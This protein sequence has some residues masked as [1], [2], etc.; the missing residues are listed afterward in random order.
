MTQ[1][2]W[3][4]IKLAAATAIATS[5]AASAGSFKIVY[6]FQG[7][8][9]GNEPNAGLINV[10]GMLYG[11]TT[12]GG[13]GCP[14]GAGCG[15]VFAVNPNT[16]AEKVIYYF[17]GGNDGNF[18]FAS[19]LSLGGTLYGT[20]ELGGGTMCNDLGCGTVFSVNPTTGVERV[21]Y[22]FQAGS[23]GYEP[24]ASLISV[25][26]ILYGTTEFGGTGGCDGGCGTVFAVNP[27]TDVEKLIHS[28]RFEGDGKNPIASLIKV[29]S[30]LYGTTPSSDRHPHFGAVISVN[31][32][33]GAEKVLH[34]FRG[35]LTDGADPNASLINLG[36]TLYGTTSSGGG[37]GYGTVFSIDP[38]S[39]EVRVVYSFAG[40]PADGSNPRA[41]LINVKGTLYGT[42]EFGGANGYGTVFSV[43]PMTS[44]ETV[45]HSFQGNNDGKYPSAGLVA[46]GA[47]LYGT[48][49]LGGGSDAGTVF[50]YRP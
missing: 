46:V 28:F 43:N 6:P 11:T 44:T 39:R 18:P 17:Q 26:G 47:T 42:T 19:L 33:S 3:S 35:D 13:M 22:S 50:A 21:V 27:N 12:Y 25:S 1:Q 48:T 10:G 37:N 5:T 9:D 29:G 40:T 23:D 38:Q 8:S 45:V 36:G 16:S 2:L 20:T 15:T 49:V 41:S 34:S 4:L 24:F 31:P 14:I 7:S 32:N 30:K